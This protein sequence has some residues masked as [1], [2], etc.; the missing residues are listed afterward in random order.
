MG[1]DSARVCSAS[2]NPITC[3]TTGSAGP[4]K[5]TIR[6]KRVEAAVQVL[7]EAAKQI[8]VFCVAGLTGRLDRDVG[9]FGEGQQLGL[10]AIGRLAGAPRRHGHV[11]DNQS[12]PRVTLGDLA[13]SRQKQRGGG[14]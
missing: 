11:V 2:C 10:E 12:E 4:A 1:C 5:A 3:L 8:R 14:P 7:M 6:T 9:V 13:D